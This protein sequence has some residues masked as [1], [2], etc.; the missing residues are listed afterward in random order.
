MLESTFRPAGECEKWVQSVGRTG[1]EHPTFTLKRHP[2][3]DVLNTL[4]I[5]EVYVCFYF[6]LGKTKNLIKTLSKHYSLNN[7]F[8]HTPLRNSP[9]QN[10]LQL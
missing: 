1:V 10:Q 4:L 7:N 6:T 3:L 8:D 2:I 5:R 9:F